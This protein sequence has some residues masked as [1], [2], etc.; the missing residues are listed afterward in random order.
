MQNLNPKIP[1]KMAKIGKIAKFQFKK[2]VLNY[3]GYICLA[4]QYAF[5][6]GVTGYDVPFYLMMSYMI[7]N[8]DWKSAAKE[9]ELLK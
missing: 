2:N 3:I 8:N 7:Y 5:L 1:I 6:C 4:L 9:R